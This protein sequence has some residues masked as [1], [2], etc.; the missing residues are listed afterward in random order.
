MKTIISILILGAVFAIMTAPANAGMRMTLHLLNAQQISAI[1]KDPAKIVALAMS[2]DAAT[3]L[4]V[5]KD[6]H[7]IHYLLT[8]RAHPTASAQS[9]A[10]FGGQ[11]IGEDLGYGPARLLSPVEVKE[12]AKA[13]EGET[14][15]KVAVRYDPKKMDAM[16]IYPEIW[17]RDGKEALDELLDTY[18]K[19]VSFYKKAASS[20]GYVL[21]VLM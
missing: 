15:A 14:E 1:K 6:W 19:F 17:T 10:I 8:Q 7:G 9:K 16:Q 18:G 11:E 3:S 20:E 2:R 13:L 21:L 5:D 4:D 12:V